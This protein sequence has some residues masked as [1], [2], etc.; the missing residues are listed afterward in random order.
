MSRGAKMMIVK[1]VSWTILATL[2]PVWVAAQSI[3][4]PVIK[5]GDTWVYRTTIEKGKNGWT[6]ERSEI[7][8]T[9]VTS[10]LIYYTLKLAGASQIASEQF[11]NLDWSRTQ[12]IN[13]K[14][15][16]VNQPLSFPL[17]TDKTWTL[18]FT[19]QHPNK[20]HNF[21]HIN[22]KY[23]V[24][25][26]ET[27]EVPAGKFNALKIEAEGNWDAELAPNRSVTMQTQTTQD[28]TSMVTQAQKTGKAPVAGRTYKA[29]WYVPEIKRWVKAIEETYSNKGE[30]SQRTSYELESD[31]LN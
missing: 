9:R 17:S 29:Y 27:V 25:D 24:V 23:T 3:D 14:E 28:N 1:Q 5:P 12:D 7:T 19:N 31:K 10:S 18:D 16:L 11:R 21:E 26:Y 2:L 4:E 22:E 8:V 20:E 30:R 15:T 6:Q 13:G